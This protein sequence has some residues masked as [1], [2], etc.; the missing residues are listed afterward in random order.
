MVDPA[1]GTRPGQHGAYDRGTQADVWLKGPDGKPFIGIVWPGS[2]VFPDWFHPAVKAFWNKEFELF[3]NPDDGFNIDGVWIDMNE[4]ASF[5]YYPCSV[6]ID[7]VNVTEVMLTLDD[8]PPLE[9]VVPVP[10]QHE[11]HEKL[12]LQRP[13]YAIRNYL[14]R[15]S[16]RTASVDIV[17]HNGLLEY[18]TRT[19][20]IQPSG[21]HC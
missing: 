9:P 19:F 10:G 15:L 5:C 13:P 20:K 8:V 11:E 12:D 3:F 4:P 18:D 6:V 1:I 16:D 21:M 14:P 7:N 17:H 2:T